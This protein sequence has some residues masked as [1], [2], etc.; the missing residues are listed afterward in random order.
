[1][2]KKKNEFTVNDVSLATFLKNHGSKMI[3]IKNGKY[4]FEYDDTIEENLKLYEDT[5]KKCMF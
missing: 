5:L 3:E 1:M 2:D 4:I